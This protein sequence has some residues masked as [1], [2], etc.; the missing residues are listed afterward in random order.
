MN[1]KKLT[2]KA[3][4]T[5]T[6]MKSRCNNKKCN[7]YEKYGAKGIRVCIR[8]NSFDNFLQDV[9]LPPTLD[10][11]IDRINPLGHYEPSNCRWATQKT[12]QNNRTNNHRYEYKGKKLTLVEWADHTGI[13]RKT[14]FN[15]LK[16]GWSLE[17]ALTEKPILGRNQSYGNNLVTFNGK[18]Q[19]IKEWA[20]EIGIKQN[21]LQDRLNRY[22]W[23]VE[24]ALTTKLI[25]DRKKSK[26]TD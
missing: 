13:Q 21:T 8:W 15:R 6:N 17:K 24:R 16:L 10:H 7:G 14:I 22:K 11:T 5:L 9:G 23:P 2:K 25:I 19:T 18:S 12:Q 20:K 4:N 3:R 1:L 26:N